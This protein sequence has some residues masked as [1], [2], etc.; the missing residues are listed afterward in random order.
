MD[1]DVNH[2]DKRG[3]KPAAAWNISIKFSN[4]E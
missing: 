2:E 3:D 4:G 1:N